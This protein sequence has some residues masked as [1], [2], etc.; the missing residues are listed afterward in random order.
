MFFT[1]K[2]KSDRP[3]KMKEDRKEGDRWVDE[4]Q[5]RKKKSGTKELKQRVNR[6]KTRAAEG[7]INRQS[8]AG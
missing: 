6:V 5:I 4:T 1:S 8:E 7:V 3:N 2:T